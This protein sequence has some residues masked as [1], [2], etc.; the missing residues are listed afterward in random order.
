M[1]EIYKPQRIMQYQALKGHMHL[2]TTSRHFCK[3][4]WSR[5]AVTNQEN[6]C[7]E[8]YS[9]VWKVQISNFDVYFI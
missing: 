4:E 3:K 8:P 2:Q 9:F 5:P 6:F 7:Y 1:Q